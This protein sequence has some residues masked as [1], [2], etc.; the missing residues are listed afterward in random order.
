V[1]TSAQITL[2]TSTVSPGIVEWQASELPW[3]QELSD[4]G[5]LAS[6]ERPQPE[7]PTADSVKH[8]RF[9]EAA[10]YESLRCFP[11]APFGGSRVLDQ[12]V[13]V[14]GAVIPKGTMIN[15]SVWGLHYSSSAWGPDAGRWRP[16]RW[17]EGRS[18]NAV[19]RDARG[20][21]RWVP[22]TQGSQNCLGQ[23][24]AVVR[25]CSFVIQC[26]LCHTVQAA[27]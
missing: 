4:A 11:P 17:L 18:C 5:M 7:L 21:L 26:K 20:N 6:D 24:L 14:E 25:P 2:L 16:E 9:L 3:L 23:H 10:I 1:C 19:K 22:F 27:R 15:M 12:V 13:T 8:L